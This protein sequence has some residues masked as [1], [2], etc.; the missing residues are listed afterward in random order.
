LRDSLIFFAALIFA[1][2]ELRHLLGVVVRVADQARKFIVP[3]PRLVMLTH[4]ALSVTVQNDDDFL[5]GQRP[6]ITVLQ[7]SG[8]PLAQQFI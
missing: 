8:A 7:A 5:E 4:P 3:N 1:C 2:L 6:E